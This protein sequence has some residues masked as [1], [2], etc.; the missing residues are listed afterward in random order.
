[1][2]KRISQNDEVTKVFYVYLSAGC[3]DTRDFGVLRP[4]VGVFEEGHHRGTHISTG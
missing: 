4:A 1:M 3:C 2:L